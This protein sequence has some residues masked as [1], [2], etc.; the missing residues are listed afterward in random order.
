MLKAVTQGGW[1]EHKSDVPSIISPYFDMRDEM[2][3]QDGL[4]FKGERVVVPRASRRELLK[5]TNY[6][7][8]G[9][10][11]CLLA[12]GDSGD[13]KPYIYLRGMSRT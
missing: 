7:Y 9:V 2:T 8:R 10:N 5:H 12:R 4:I 1:P 6:S 3:I 13:Q 11:G